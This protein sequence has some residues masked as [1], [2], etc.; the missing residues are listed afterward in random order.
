MPKGHVDKVDEVSVSGWVSGLSEVSIYVD[1]SLSGSATCALRR[2]DLEEQGDRTSRGFEYHFPESIPIASVVRVC[3]AGGNDIPGSPIVFIDLAIARDDLVLVLDS[4]SKFASHASEARFV[5]SLMPSQYMGDISSFDGLIDKAVFEAIS[6]QDF[7]SATLLVKTF[8]GLVG[9]SSLRRYAKQSPLDRAGSKSLQFI[10]Y[11]LRLGRLKASTAPLCFD[12]CKLDGGKILL[13]RSSVKGMLADKAKELLLPAGRHVDVEVLATNEYDRECPSIKAFS[14]DNLYPDVPVH[15]GWIDDVLVLPQRFNVVSRD[16]AIMLDDVTFSWR[17]ENY[18][19]NVNSGATG[20]E[21][22]PDGRDVILDLDQEWVQS[23][24][25]HFLLGGVQN[26]GH[27]LFDIVPRLM[28]I[29]EFD[30]DISQMKFVVRRNRTP[31]E[32]YILDKFSIDKRI[33]IDLGQIL[34]VDRCFISSTF[35]KENTISPRVLSFLRGRLGVSDV[36]EPGVR[37]RRIFVSREP[38]RE[39]DELNGRALKNEAEV[40]ALLASMGFERVVMEGLSVAEQIELFKA[41]SVVVTPTGSAIN[42]IIFSALDINVVELKT[43]DTVN[44]DFAKVANM[45]GVKYTVI[46]SWHSG[47]DLGL[48]ADAV[49]D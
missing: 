45:M 11:T 43:W 40:W 9:W 15:F 25:D 47:V 24:G 5:S 33:E 21:Y 42:N 6:S 38:M 36:A 35:C 12:K 30:L 3:D 23:N 32:D 29:E 19:S 10:W 39:V 46:P 7:T 4:F 2:G 17:K 34:Q 16:C 22:S 48:L 13:H 37:R 8:G 44:L 41:A 49:N 1:G 28:L 31:W 18:F 27:W 26:F 14:S 20:V